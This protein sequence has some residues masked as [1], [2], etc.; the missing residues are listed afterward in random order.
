MRLLLEGGASVGAAD[1]DGATALLLACAGGYPEIARLLLEA[2]AAV[3]QARND[4]IAPLLRACQEGR[5]DIVRLLLE[6]SAAVN[7]AKDDGTTPLYMACQE[8]HLEIARL[9]LE[10]G[11]AVNQ[12]DAG[13][14]TPLYV[15]SQNSHLECV[16]L[17][18]KT[19]AAV[20][21][22]KDDGATPLFAACYEGHLEVAKLLSFHGASRAATPFGTP[23]QAANR[24][25]HADLAA[26]LVASRGWTPLQHLEAC[27]RLAAEGVSALSSRPLHLFCRRSPS[28]GRGRCCAAA[29]TLQPARL[30]PSSGRASSARGASR[31]RL[32]RESVPQ[33]RSALSSRGPR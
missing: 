10:A 28:S 23:E 22:A 29:R 12:A 13:G 11:A 6:A 3:G 20:N 16:R 17:L 25:G 7:Q 8:G 31:I 32:L 21:Q 4:G 33:S 19:S 27:P 9:L 15:A 2:D 30:L 1:G 26:W 14:V 24:E 5:F 18:L